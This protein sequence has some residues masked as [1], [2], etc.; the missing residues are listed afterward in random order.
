MNDQSMLNTFLSRYEEVNLEDSP[1]TLR[2]A[3]KRGA[4]DFFAISTGFAIQ[5]ND[6]W[7]VSVHLDRQPDPTEL[8]SYC[9][10]L[11]L[12]VDFMRRPNAPSPKFPN[13]DEPLIWTYPKE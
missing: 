2:I 4:G 5:G 13:S 6:R 3:S 12:I 7:V 1:C 9:K 11:E 10:T 8:D